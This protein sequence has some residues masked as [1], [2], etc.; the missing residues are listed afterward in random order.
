MKHALPLVVALMIAGGIAAP[1]T[2]SSGAYA[3]PDHELLVPV[4]GG[5]V[6][7][8]VNGQIGHG[9]IPVVF[10]HGGPGGTHNGFAQALGLADERA[11][12]LYDQL[13]SGRSDRP[14]NPANWRVARFVDELETI[15]KT[16]GVERWHVVGHSWGSAVALEYAARYPQH[17]ASTVLAGTY[18]STARWIADANRLLKTLPAPVQHTIAACERPT[19]PPAGACQAATAV[20]Y[21]TYNG[22]EPTSDRA[23]AYAKAIGGGGG[24][25]VIYNA[26]WGPSEFRANG[27]LKTYDATPLL[28]RL[29]GAKT[30]F[31]IGQYDEARIETVEAFARRTKGAELAVIPGA[32]HG[33]FGDR[34][35]ETEAVL[36]G[37]LRRH[38]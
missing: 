35:I 20:F 32:A 25:A 37:W 13:D 31:L 22:R 19:P 3:T 34:P 9:A 14:D 28:A 6:Y 1:V 8:R 33:I 15:R 16:L 7:V 26:M 18:I 27:S 38:D 36:R 29:D 12:I 10:I 11:V 21:R 5:R 2:G 17:I 30:L 23:R 4:E 24:N